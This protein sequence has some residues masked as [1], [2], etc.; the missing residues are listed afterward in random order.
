[1]LIDP[2]LHSGIMALW[3]LFQYFLH[4]SH[5][6]F[7]DLFHISQPILINFLTFLTTFTSSIL[8]FHSH[9]HLISTPSLNPL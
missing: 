2:L 6:T 9:F 3:A 8:F 4:S 5:P 1:M 7:L